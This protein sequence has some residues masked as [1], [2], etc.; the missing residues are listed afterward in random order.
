M[1]NEDCGRVTGGSWEG[2]RRGAWGAGG[3]GGAGVM[4][5]DGGLKVE[6]LEGG[7]EGIAEKCHG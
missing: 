4:Q 6:G 5:L 2:G 1:V 3:A 7:Y